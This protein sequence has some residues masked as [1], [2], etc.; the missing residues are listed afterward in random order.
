MVIRLTPSHKDGHNGFRVPEFASAVCQNS[1]GSSSM[2]KKPSSLSF[3]G[4]P[5]ARDDEE[6]RKSCAFRARLLSRNCG[7]GMTTFTRVFQHPARG[8][9]GR[10]AYNLLPS[11]E[12]DGAK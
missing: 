8:R 10:L 6:S 11:H 3:R 9:C 2:L 5:Q 4:V 1:R 12:Q 7:I